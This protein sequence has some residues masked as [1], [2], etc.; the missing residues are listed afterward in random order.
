MQQDTFA[1]TLWP[2]ML[3][4]YAMEG[5]SSMCLRLQDE[6][7]VDVP[8]LLF[9]VLADRH[10]LKCSEADFERLLSAASVWRETVVQPLRDIRRAMKGVFEREAETAFRDEIK[11]M[12]LQAEKLHVSRLTGSF[13]PSASASGALVRRYLTEIR[14]PE[15]LMQAFA[16][17]FAPAVEALDLARKSAYE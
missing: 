5:I 1:E 10:G 4:L 9:L 14:L 15:A 13:M 3:R 17:G 6:G 12:E 7:D 11:R 2:D 16:G 8:L